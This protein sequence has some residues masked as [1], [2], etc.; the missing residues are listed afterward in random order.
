[1]SRLFV[2]SQLRFHR[3]VAKLNVKRIARSKLHT[4]FDLDVKLGNLTS[5][6][7]DNYIGLFIRTEKRTRIKQIY[8]N[9]D[10]A[11][12]TRLEKKKEIIEIVGGER[13]NKIMLGERRRVKNTYLL[14][15]IKRK[16]QKKKKNY[17]S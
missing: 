13:I 10:G 8:D 6:K 17:Y 12:I 14:M 7:D 16:R 5:R 2:A 9:L 15:E 4:S 1:M 3:S 11:L